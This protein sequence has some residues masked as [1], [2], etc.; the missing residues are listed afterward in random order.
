MQYKVSKLL[1][2]ALEQTVSRQ[3]ADMAV[4]AEERF[5]KELENLK[6]AAR[7]IS[8]HPDKETEINVLQRINKA[9]QEATVGLMNLEGQAI[10][11]VPLYK[12][13]FTRLPMVFQG[14]DVI[15][16]CIGAGLLFAVPVMNGDNV[17]AIIYKLYDDRLLTDLF[18]LSEYDSNSKFIIQ[19]RNGQI[20]VPYIDYG[21]ADKDFFT[22]LTILD[23]FQEVRKRLETN[24]AAAVYYKGPRGELFLFGA[25]LPQTNCAIIGYVPWNAIAGTIARANIMIFIVTSSLLLLFLIAS[26]YLLIINEKANKS[27]EFQQA[28]AAAD[29]ANEAKSAFLANMSH[30]IRTP[31]NAIIGLDNLALH[32]PDI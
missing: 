19:E 8:S 12:K 23:S 27:E 5:I 7:Y 20:I 30:E 22:D 28:K 31:M 15:D 24:K 16:Y 10:Y 26:V 6:M 4:V 9:D 32:D 18:G 2:A 14:N 17:R 3:T 21:E 1:I 11:G 13:D 25:D 29:Q